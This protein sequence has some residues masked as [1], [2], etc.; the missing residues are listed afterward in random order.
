[1]SRNRTQILS[2]S[3]RGRNSNLIFDPKSDE[4]RTKEEET[5]KMLVDT[6][7]TEALRADFQY[8][9]DQEPIDMSLDEFVKVNK[10]YKKYDM[11]II[12][13]HSNLVIIR[14]VDNRLM[15]QLDAKYNFKGPNYQMNK[16]V[17]VKLPHK[18]KQ[19]G[20]SRSKRRR[21]RRHSL[22]FRRQ[23]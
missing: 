12:P 18:R 7:R 15:L 13:V 20:G 1:M 16:V 17:A 21:S 8:R 4:E 19:S 14:A 9:P 3:P 2:G 6:M 23:R 10:D 5:E 22:R 11:G